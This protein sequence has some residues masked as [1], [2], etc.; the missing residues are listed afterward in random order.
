MNFFA[1]LVGLLEIVLFLCLQ[2]RPVLSDGNQ[3]RSFSLAPRLANFKSSVH[4]LLEGLRIRKKRRIQQSDELAKPG[5]PNH[6]LRVGSLA[7]EYGLS[8][9][10]DFNLTF[11]ISFQHQSKNHILIGTQQGSM[12]LF[13]LSETDDREANTVAVSVQE[14][15]ASKAMAFSYYDEQW[16]AVLQSSGESTW[17]RFYQRVGRGLEG[18]QTIALDGEADFDLVTVKGVHYLAVVT[19][20][21]AVHQSMLILY[22]WTQT[23]F[24]KITS[25][26]VQGARSVSCWVLDGSLYLAVAQEVNEGG[27]YRVG[28]PIFLYNAKD[29]DGLVLLQML[30]TY[31]PRKVRYFFVSGSHYVIFFGQEDAAIYW[32][33]T[34]VTLSS[35]HSSPVQLRILERKLG[36]SVLALKNGCQPITQHLIFDS[37]WSEIPEI[38]ENV[39]KGSYRKGEGRQCR[40]RGGVKF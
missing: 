34:M 3:T 17:L 10:S 40:H 29:D 38:N 8:Y 12:I 19:Y 13:E 39:D 23:Q 9:L 7:Q 15:I 16:F 2:T 18:R 36:E 32:W 24:D 25:R 1:S 5:T 33:S 11:W 28:S 30:D 21:T 14:H 4:R 37:T 20:R 35:Q 26:S 22:H 6:E 31:G 27:N